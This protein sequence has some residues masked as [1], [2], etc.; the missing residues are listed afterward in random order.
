[1]LAKL[2]KKA[3]VVFKCPAHC[4]FERCCF[5]SCTGEKLVTL[6]NAGKDDVALEELYA[7]S[8]VST[9]AS[10]AGEMPARLEG[11]EAVRQKHQW[12]NSNTKT[13]SA[14]A[15][16]PFVGFADDE[17]VVRFTM[18]V[19]MGGE[20]STMT[21]VGIYKVADGKIVEDRYLGLA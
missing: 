17:F 20:R 13:H 15:E 1:M 11:I 12:W 5:L 18:D 21:E 2:V 19:T 9:E 7:D 8:I 6:S 3:W 10:A 4:I 16:G 14:S